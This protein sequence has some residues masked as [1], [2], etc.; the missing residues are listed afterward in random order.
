MS[1]INYLLNKYALGTC[2]REEF[3]EL[4]QLLPRQENEQ[5]LRSS[6]RKFNESL[7]M[8]VISTSSVS[9]EGDLVKEAESPAGKKRKLTTLKKWSIAASI[10]FCLGAVTWAVNKGK[11]FD[12]MG[13]EPQLS[14]VTTPAGSKT[15]VILPDGSK[16]W[17][18]SKSTLSYTTGFVGDKREVW[19]EGEAMFDVKHDSL[20]PFLVH[21]ENFDVTDLGTV[22]NI[23]AYPEDKRAEAALISGSIEIALKKVRS[24]NILLVPNQKIVV[25]NGRIAVQDIVDKD[26]AIIKPVTK[27]PQTQMIADT[28]WM[29]NKLLFRDEYFNDL[30]TKLERRYSVEIHFKDKKCGLYKFTGRFEDE[31]IEEALQELQAIAPFDYKKDKNQISISN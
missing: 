9:A 27:D 4:M 8:E 17:L 26:Q 7:D 2:T 18:N 6:L 20:H 24:K 28:A 23:Q 25:Q 11:L 1:R 19:L 21:T 29:A 12:F 31:T 15:S 5:E 13:S 3:D 22:F 16:V 10:L 30:A 14:R